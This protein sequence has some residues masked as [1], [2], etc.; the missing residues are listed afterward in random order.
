[1]YIYIK[2]VLFFILIYL[3]IK[4]VFYFNLFIL[5]VFL[6]YFSSYLNFFLYLCLLSFLIFDRSKP[7]L[8]PNQVIARW[9]QL[10]T[11]S[12][13]DCMV[14]GSGPLGRASDAHDILSS[15]IHAISLQSGY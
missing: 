15:V 2:F 13:S 4:F 6:I 1:M 5:I 9:Y 12:L 11:I 8:I 3:F 10:L 14:K 7:S